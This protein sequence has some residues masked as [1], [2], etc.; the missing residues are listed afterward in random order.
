RSPDRRY[1]R[2]YPVQGALLQRGNSARRTRGC[3]RGRFGRKTYIRI[4]SGLRHGFDTKS[5][6]EHNRDVSKVLTSCGCVKPTSSANIRTKE[7]RMADQSQTV[8]INRPPRIQPDLPQSDNE[9]PPPPE[10]DKGGQQLIQLFLPLITI[11]AY[12]LVSATGQG[13]NIALII[14]I[15]LS[16]I[17]S[18]GLGF[19]TYHKNQRE[20]QRKREAYETRLA[21]LRREMEN[22]HDQQRTFY[23][24]NYP[25]I[26]TVKA[27]AANR[28]TGSKD[29]RTGTR[30][31]ER[32]TSDPDFGAV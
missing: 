8:L 3:R 13:R 1:R 4:S 18:S 25:N 21:E 20:T 30:L 2:P 26:E 31:W 9:I 12:V 6:S 15:G 16:V 10:T 32:R 5:H 14:P 28:E 17:A 22:A 29:N 19:W 7:C 11:I 24:Y 27:I 23:Y